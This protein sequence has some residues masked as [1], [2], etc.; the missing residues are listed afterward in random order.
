M[1]E[2]HLMNDPEHYTNV[3]M[4]PNKLFVVKRILRYQSDEN[5]EKRSRYREEPSLYRKMQILRNLENFD[6]F[7]LLAKEFY[8]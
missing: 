6:P 7:L 1:K 4:L 3:V 2:L 5:D 8:A